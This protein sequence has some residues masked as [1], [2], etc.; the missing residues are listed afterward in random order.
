MDR[1]KASC[2]PLRWNES[3][4]N[5]SQSV[6]LSNVHFFVVLLVLN[7]IKCACGCA[8]AYAY[9]CA[10]CS[11]VLV[12]VLVLCGAVRLDTRSPKLHSSVFRNILSCL[13]VAFL[14]TVHRAPITEQRTTTVRFIIFGSIT[15][16]M[17]F[18]F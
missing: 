13:F 10:L 16:C 2:V 7:N 18:H 17:N 8:C 11:A 6:S 12:L 9:A 14:S 4:E 3:H 1:L 5:V 15:S